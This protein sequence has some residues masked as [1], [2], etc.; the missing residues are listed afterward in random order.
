MN[1]NRLRIAIQKSGRLSEQT[2]HL[3][4]ECG[5]KYSIGK[6]SLMSSSRT[7]PLDLLLLRDDDIPQ[8][9]EDGIAHIGILGE[10][11]V[12][13]KADNV[14][15]IK[16]LGFSKCR[17]SLA[18]PKRIDYP[19]IQYFDGKEIAT[20]YPV[21][22][23]KYLDKA[24]VKVD[25]HEISGSVEIAPN[26]GLAD[27]IFDI[28]STG[29]TLRSNG[30]KEVEVLMESEAVLIATNDLATPQQ[31]L[32]DELLFRMDTVMHAKDKKYVMLN[33]PKAKLDQVIDLLPGVKSPT[34]MNLADDNWVAIHAVLSEADFWKAVQPLNELGATDILVSNIE[35]MVV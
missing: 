31:Q 7:F 15:I 12:E 18:I 20:S 9:V 11:V 35:R 4:Q 17:L 1:E 5:I 23:Q 3:L 2:N 28:V 6:R 29:G 33:A 19:G 14:Q 22:L 21:I 10:N 13:E 34:V 30:L 25:V 8:Y 24:G 32:L 26:I 27:G 16:R